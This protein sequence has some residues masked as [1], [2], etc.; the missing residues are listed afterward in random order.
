[1]VAWGQRSRKVCS[2]KMCERVRRLWP[3]IA[4]RCDNEEAVK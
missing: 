1:M 4:E 2:W 3:L